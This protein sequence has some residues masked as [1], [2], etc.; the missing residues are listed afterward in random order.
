MLRTRNSSWDWHGLHSAVER[1][2]DWRRGGISRGIGAWGTIP[3]FR[4]FARLVRADCN[5]RGRGWRPDAGGR[6]AATWSPNANRISASPRFRGAADRRR[7]GD[8]AGD[9]SAARSILVTVA[10]ASAD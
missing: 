9:R 4:D 6:A 8:H 7:G 2:L 1:H 10:I 3:E 5:R